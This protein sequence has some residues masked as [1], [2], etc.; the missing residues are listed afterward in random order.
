MK[1]LT[2]EEIT[3]CRECGLC[4]NYDERY[5][6]G[7]RYASHV[8]LL[9]TEEEEPATANIN[10][11][12]PQPDPPD[13]PDPYPAQISL[14]SLSGHLAPETLCFEG[15]ITDHHLVL[16]VDGGSTHNFV[17]QQ[18]VTR[19]GLPC[20]STLPLRVMVGNGHHMECTTICEAVPISIQDIEFTVD[21]YVLPIVEANVV[22]GVQWLKTLGHILTDYN[23]LCMQF[24]YQNRLV[25]LKGESEAQLGLLNHHQLCRLRHTQEPVSYFHIAILTEPHTS[26][27]TPPPFP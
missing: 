10:P 12:D 22:L 20:C 27:T 3:S 14:H 16:L 11:N 5:H 6:R 1:R 26:S 19:L 8:F 21:L 9:I 13:A 15:V 18:L 23:S 24:F 2:P 4:F 17:Q 7:H 25:Q